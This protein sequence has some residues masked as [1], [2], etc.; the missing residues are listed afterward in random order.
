MCYVKIISLILLAI[1]LIFTAL[2]N[3]LGLHLSSFANFLFGLVPVTSG[4][5]M[6]LGIHEYCEHSEEE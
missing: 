5:L 3:F 4:I 6:L 1:Y 2:S